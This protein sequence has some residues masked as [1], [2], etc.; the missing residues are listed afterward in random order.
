[1]P[2]RPNRLPIRF[3]DAELTALRARATACG[4]PVARFVRES[5]LGAIPRALRRQRA[6]DI[7]SALSQIARALAAPSSAGGKAG[8]GAASARDVMP[9]LTQLLDQ[10]TASQDR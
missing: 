6:D 9:R 10:L 8:G 5:A 7:V 1:M 3:S 4:R 2:N